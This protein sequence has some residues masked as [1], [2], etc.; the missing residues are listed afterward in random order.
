[1][2]SFDPFD[3]DHIKRLDLI[4]RSPFGDHHIG[5]IFSCIA[6][7]NE[8]IA[9]SRTYSS[10]FSRRILQKENAKRIS[11]SVYCY[12]GDGPIPLWFDENRGKFREL[13][14]LEA[15]L[16]DRCTD[17]AK[18]CLGGLIDFWTLDFEVELKL[19]TTEVEARIK[20]E[21]D[22]TTRYG[23]VRVVYE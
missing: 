18:S 22:G 6:K 16:S 15:D 14:K 4:K 8:S 9:E 7:K 3:E 10:S 5:P 13:C 2:T 19:G 17:E 21:Q 11:S 23:P 12:D 20:W 1:V